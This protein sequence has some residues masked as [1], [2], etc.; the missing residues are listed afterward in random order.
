MA[1]NSNFFLHSHLNFLSPDVQMDLS[2]WV[3]GHLTGGLGNRLFQHAAAA[4]LSERWKIPLVFYVPDCTPTGHGPFDNIFKL[5]PAVPR[6]ETPVPFQRLPEPRNGVF[7][8]NPFSSKPPFPYLTVD[9]Y[10]Q[11]ELYFPSKGIQP[12][13]ANA[14]PEARR[15]DLLSQF[16]LESQED[17]LTTWFLHIRMGDYKVLPH[18]QIDLASYY[19]Q[20]VK[21]IPPGAKVLLFSDEIKEYGE[22]FTGFFKQFGVECIPAVVPDELECLYVMSQCWGG[23]VVANSTFSWWGAYCAKQSHPTPFLYKAIYPAK[24][25]KGLPEAKDIVPL[26][27]IRISNE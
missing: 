15:K 4:G 19:P 2:S 23:A 13:F 12:E 1:A 27:G 9:G 20:A 16:H 14:I 17:R 25:G 11:S 3:A 5:F 10:R 8:Y 21:H 6:V 7:T 22:F 18:H 24:W 26:W